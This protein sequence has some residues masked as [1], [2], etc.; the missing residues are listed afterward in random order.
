MDYLYLDAVSWE[1]SQAIYHAA[2]YLGR[3]VLILLR[4][5]TPYVC[6]GYHQDAQQEIDLEYAASASDSCISS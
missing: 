5:S 1:Y 4:P 6:I 2:A 3:E